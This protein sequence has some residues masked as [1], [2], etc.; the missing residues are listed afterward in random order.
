GGGGGFN[1]YMATIP[2]LNIG[3]FVVITRKA[4]G[5]KFSEVTR[6]TNALVRALAQSF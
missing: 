4:N 2:E 5:T 6:G 3:V 1:T